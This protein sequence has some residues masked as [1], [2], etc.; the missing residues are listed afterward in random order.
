MKYLSILL[1]LVLVSAGSARIVSVEIAGFA[2]HPP[3]VTVAIGD[4]VR[5]TNHDAVHHT[6]TSGKPDSSPG[7]IWDAPYINPNDSF[8]L[9]ITFVRDNIP[10]FCRVHNSI[11][12]F[13]TATAAIAE[14]RGEARLQ[15]GLRV[16]GV[17][18]A[19]VALSLTRPARVTVEI[20]DVQGR[21]VLVL[22]RNRALAAGRTALSIPQGRLGSGVY[23][24]TL[25]SIAGV[26]TARTV[27]AR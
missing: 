18:A 21:T 5:W 10:Y 19:A 7:L 22:A 23:L 27:V 25:R 15:A 3:S 4:T 26:S 13:L 11:R 8:S 16:P 1:L 12:G 2:F 9:P 24:A 14:D 20:R 6:T 17:N